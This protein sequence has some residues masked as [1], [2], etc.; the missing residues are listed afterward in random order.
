MSA[1]DCGKLARFIEGLD[2][3]SK[4]TGVRFEG[5]GNKIEMDGDSLDLGLWYDDQMGAY[6]LEVVTSRG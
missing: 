5:T 4:Q 2:E 6:R 3:L 1:E